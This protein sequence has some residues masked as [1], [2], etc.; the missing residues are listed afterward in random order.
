MIKAIVALML[1]HFLSVAYIILWLIDEKLLL[2]KANL[3]LDS[4]IM[5]DGIELGWYIKYVS[6]HVIWCVTYWVFSVVAFSYNK[7]LFLVVTMLAIYHL[8][9]FVCFLV[10]F[11]MSWWFYWVL[12]LALL[13]CVIILMLP[14]K[15][16][17]KIISIE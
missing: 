11:N 14:I 4:S 8:I 7:K 2:I 5:P 13:S 9:D 15:E 6:D 17:A 1:A 3:F 10:N 16:K 12:I